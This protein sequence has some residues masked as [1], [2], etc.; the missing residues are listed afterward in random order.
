MIK[1]LNIL[2]EIKIGVSIEEL[3]NLIVQCFTLERPADLHNNYFSLIAK[4]GWNPFRSNPTTSKK[5]ETWD[6]WLENMNIKQR[7]DFYNDLKQFI[8]KNKNK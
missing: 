8:N 4:H 7:M 1:L 5:G 2:Q 6:E 3:T